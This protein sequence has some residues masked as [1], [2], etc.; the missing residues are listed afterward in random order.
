VRRWPALAAV[1]W[2]VACG[3]EPEPRP[4]STAEAERLALV[5]FANYRSRTGNFTA[6]VPTTGGRIELRGRVDFVGHL[7]YAELSTDGREDDTSAGLLQWTPAALAFRGGVGQAATDPPPTDRWQYRPLEKGPELDT[8]LWLLLGLGAD[9]PDNVQLL[10]QSSARW[11]R[12][13]TI[14]GTSVVID[15]PQPARP[16]A[17]TTASRMRYWLDGAGMLRRI[18]ARI[19]DRPDPVAITFALT[20]APPPDPVPAFA[21]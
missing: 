6:A 9:R 18:E 13:D 16:S 10:Q 12:T 20:T 4:L 17:T 2:V 15:G 14:D 8:T 1:L 3:A 11:V 19:G 5:R 7:G 21:R